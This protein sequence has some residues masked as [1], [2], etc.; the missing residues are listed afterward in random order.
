MRHTRWIIAGAIALMVTAGIAMD[1]GYERLPVRA[2]AAEPIAPPPAE[3][4]TRTVADGPVFEFG[5][6]ME[7][8]APGTIVNVEL[9]GGARI[10]ATLLRQ[11][12][13]NLALDL[14]HDV[15]VLP[16]ARVASV[17]SAG[18]DGAP[19]DESRLESSDIYTVGKLEGGSVRDLV[20]QFGDSI[21]MIRTPG[22]VGSGFFISDRGHIISNYHVVENETRV[23]VT[24]FE[25]RPTGYEKRDFRNVR[26]L[27]LHPLRDLALLQIDPEDLKDFKPN[28]LVISSEEVRQGDL[29]FAIGNPLGLERTVTQGI[30]SSTT[31]TLGHLRFIQTD[32]AINPGNS[33]GPMFNARGEVVGV[34][35]AGFTFFQGLAFG[36]PSSDLVDFLKHRN[37][38]LFDPTQPN[39]GIRYLEPPYTGAQE[40]DEE[41]R[42]A[43]GEAKA[44]E[45]DDS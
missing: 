18:T 38:Y 30:V 33:G 6:A 7:E 45:A 39:T 23:S 34:V 1:M 17:R 14:G 3:P 10:M 11:N 42:S 22:G 43:D 12:R 5:P 44:N 25:R 2:M 9:V 27:A 41:G 16:T 20:S 29:V 32:A 26:I 4:T 36:I 24:M 28:P 15:L 35:C 37:A 21:V 31:R 40:N 8:I 13:E 19:V